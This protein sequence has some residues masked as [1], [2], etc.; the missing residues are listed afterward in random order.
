MFRSYRFHLISLYPC[1]KS[2]NSPRLFLLFISSAFLSVPHFLSSSTVHRTML[3]LT[4]PRTCTCTHTYYPYSLIPY[5][6]LTSYA[7]CRLALVL[8]IEPLTETIPHA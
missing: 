3:C 7:L 5:P 4:R 2:F 6:S 1:K 8:E